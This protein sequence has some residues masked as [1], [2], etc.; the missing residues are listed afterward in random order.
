MTDR[1]FVFR[2]VTL[3]GKRPFM[4]AFRES[5]IK[6][7]ETQLGSQNCYLRVNGIDVQGSF[8]EFVGMLGKRV[9][10]K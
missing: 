4:Y 3:E 6:I 5:D 8:D 2:Q 10:I 7:V 9:D 1:V